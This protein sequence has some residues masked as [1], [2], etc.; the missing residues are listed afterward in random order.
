MEKFGNKQGEI[1]VEFYNIY[2][3]KIGSILIKEENEKIVQIKIIK[4]EKETLA[5][6]QETALIK[7]AYLQIQE[8]LEQKRRK[9]TLP[10]LLKGTNFQMKVWQALRT[11]PYGETRSYEEIAKQ[12][13]NSKAARAVGMA[14]HNNPI[15]IVVPCHR[16]IGKNN[17]LVGFGAGLEVKQA[18]L[19]IENMKII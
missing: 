16:V 9:F 4:E 18:L 17:K 1:I 11:I 13:G 3:T 10:L 7:E 14:N 19:E 2:K 6:K 5:K 15:L 12:I 8:Y